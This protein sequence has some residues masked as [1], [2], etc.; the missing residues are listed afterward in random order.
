MHF[1]K[2]VSMTLCGGDGSTVAEKASSIE[3]VEIIDSLCA[4]L[5]HS[6]QPF[7]APGSYWQLLAALGLSFKLFAALG[8]S[9]QLITAHGS[10]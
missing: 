7:T 1:M 10:S 2:F 3:M 6:W 9:W 8:R 5:G 4:A